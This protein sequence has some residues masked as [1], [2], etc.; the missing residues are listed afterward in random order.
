[1]TVDTPAFS[2]TNVSIKS[3]HDWGSGVH[4]CEPMSPKVYPEVLLATGLTNKETNI[5]DVYKDM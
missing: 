1:M 3:L 5:S 2:V 4:S